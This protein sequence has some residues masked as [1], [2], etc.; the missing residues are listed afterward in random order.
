M[1]ISIITPSYNQGFL[2]DKTIESVI[3]QD[4]EEVEYIVIDGGSNDETFQTVQKYENQIA[5]FISEPDKGQS[6]AINKGLHISKGDVVAYLNS[7][8]VL[9]PGAL[10]IVA[11]F[12]SDNSDI[13]IVY[14]DCILINTEGKMI[15][16][17]KEIEFDFIMGCMIGFGKIIIQPSAF[18]RRKVLD[19]VGYFNESLNYCMDA[20]YWYRCAKLGM[21]FKH[22]PIFLSGFRLHPGSKTM[23]EIGSIVEAKI[24]E[25][26]KVT[27]EAYNTLWISKF[28]PYEFSKPIR[29]GYRLKRIITKLL[30][31]CY[32]IK[33]IA[34]SNIIGCLE[35]D[36]QDVPK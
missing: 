29:Q 19:K 17:K 9:L 13:D 7:D 25:S 32:S 4:W 2:I 33:P 22:I 36:C 31:G 15:R 20:E 24:F 11:Q 16:P 30:K 26:E 6:D 23:S 14:G 5:H 35:E 28:L 3:K 21:R 34:D 12:F 8:D 10:K 1:K 18:M 27:K